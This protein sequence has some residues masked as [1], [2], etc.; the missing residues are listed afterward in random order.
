MSMSLKNFADYLS[1]FKR[2]NEAKRSPH[3]NCEACGLVIEGAPRIDADTSKSFNVGHK[4]CSRERCVARIAT[5]S[6]KRR[7]IQYR[8][9]VG[10][11]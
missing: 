11:N 5:M 2:T 6:I 3:A 1:Q 8:R 4:L 10:D 7:V 9:N